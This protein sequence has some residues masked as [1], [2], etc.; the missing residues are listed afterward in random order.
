M[1]ELPHTLKTG[2]NH[3]FEFPKPRRNETLKLILS[4]ISNISGQQ[5]PQDN[6]LKLRTASFLIL[7]LAEATGH[8]TFYRKIHPL[9]SLVTLV[10]T[11][12][13]RHGTPVAQV[14]IPWKFFLKASW[15]PMSPTF[16]LNHAWSPSIKKKIQGAGAGKIV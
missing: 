14:R 9:G 4:G 11:K 8:N 6:L 3:L 10:G 5:S 13:Q 16:L 7:Y 15:S 1:E 2:F 12:S